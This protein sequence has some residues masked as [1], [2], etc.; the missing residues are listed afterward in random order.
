MG[1]T[2]PFFILGS[3]GLLLAALARATTAPTPEPTALP[4][5]TAPDVQ[6][7]IGNIYWEYN[8]SAND[9]GVHVTLDGEDWKG[10]VIEDPNEEILFQVKGRGPY[11]EFGMTELFFEG[12][13]PSLDEVPLAEL[14]AKFPE[15]L[16]EFSG[17]TVSGEEIERIDLLSHAIPAGPSVSTSLVRG[18]VLRIH[19]TPVT[20]PPPGFPHRPIHITGYQVIVGSFLVTVPPSVFTVTVP[21]EYYRTLA[22]GVQPYEVL[23]IEQ[24]GNQTLTE[25]TFIR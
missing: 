4:T 25:G 22:P 10:L 15:G 19:W 12:A 7:S 11:R 24:S 14:L 2:Q 1:H 18:E 9:L 16:Y 8:S 6:F 21:P 13:E 17:F 3:T 20:T 5:P 23:A